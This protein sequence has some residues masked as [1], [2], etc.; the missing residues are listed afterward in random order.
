[1]DFK[2]FFSFTQIFDGNSN[3][4]EIKEN[5]IDPPIIARYLRLY[6]TEVYNRPTLRMELLGCEVDGKNCSSDGAPILIFLT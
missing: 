4:Y 1:M 2:I 5:T 3:A 6:P